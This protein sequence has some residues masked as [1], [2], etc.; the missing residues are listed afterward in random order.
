[1]I[2]LVFR[3]RQIVASLPKRDNRK[4]AVWICREEYGLSGIHPSLQCGIL[5]IQVSRP[6]VNDVGLRSFHQA[7]SNPQLTS[8]KFPCSIVS[9]TGGPS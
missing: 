9:Q 5:L 7:E 6:E 3:K 4:R 8:G 1:M 2:G